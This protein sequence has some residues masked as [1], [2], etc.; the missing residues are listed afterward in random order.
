[1]ELNV[2]Q[3][4]G[5][6]EEKILKKINQIL[7]NDMDYASGKILGSMCTK[8]LQFVNKIYSA[9]L[10]K[11]LGDP[12]L[13]LGTWSMEREVT[14]L[15]GKLLHSDKAVGYLVTG[16]TEANLIAVR[17]ARNHKDY[18][19]HDK[20]LIV[21]L[22]AHASFDKA[23][24]LM[25]FNLIKCPLNEEFS[26]DIEA[27]KEAISPKTMGIVGVAG[28][29]SL[30]TV[31][32]IKA[33]S[34]LAVDNDIY[35]H[36]DSAFG[37]FVLP[38]LKELGYDVPDYD[39]IHE[40]VK[41]ITIDPHKMGLGPI[42]AGSIIFNDK[43]IVGSSYFD[44]PYLAGGHIRQATIVGTRSGASVIATWAIIKYLGRKGYKAIVKKCMQLTEYFADQ[45]QYIDGIELARNPIMN[46]LGFTSSKYNLRKIDKQL[47]RKGWALGFFNSKPPLLRAVIMPHIKKCHVDNFLHD[48]EK[49]T[50][51]L[52][53]INSPQ[54][55]SQPS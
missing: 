6:C 49:I 25:R 20:E 23:A 2:I 26:V 33:L 29:T 17:T 41:S 50:K 52:V 35:L 32:D 11:N 5:I 51:K 40:G 14:S 31:D 37:G 38:F 34:D 43:S 9:Y 16:G 27:V 24:D 21:P 1:M 47:R 13:W 53:P 46:V 19:K 30:G 4:D 39:F 48:L 44:I 8:P 18:Y 10:D 3:E 12:G 42:P 36:V 15:I 54:T 45:L 7:G 22:S 28:S 55:L